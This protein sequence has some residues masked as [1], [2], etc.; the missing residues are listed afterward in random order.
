[1]PNGVLTS[2]KFEVNANIRFRKLSRHQKPRHCVV[3]CKDRVGASGVAFATGGRGVTVSRVGLAGVSGLAFSFIIIIII[4]NEY[5]YGGV[6]P[7]T[8]R[9]PHNEKRN[10]VDRRQK[11]T[12]Q[13][14]ERWMLS[15]ILNSSVLSRDRKA[16]MDVDSVT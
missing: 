15:G 14:R 12:T 3:H 1:M 4:M 11:I 6:S 5:D 13:F 10:D 9:T 2:T 16:G 7:R 8:A